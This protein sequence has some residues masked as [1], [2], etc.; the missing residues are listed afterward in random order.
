MFELI[1]AFFESMTTDSAEFAAKQNAK[2]EAEVEE[3]LAKSAEAV[4]G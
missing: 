3:L 4:E 1:K 2:V